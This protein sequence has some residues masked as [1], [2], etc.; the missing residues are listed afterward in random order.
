MNRGDLSLQ[1]NGVT[2]CDQEN[3]SR[4]LISRFANSTSSVTAIAGTRGAGKSSL[5]LRVMRSSNNDH[6][7]T[8]I[9]HCPIGYNPREFLVSIFQSVTD[10]VISLIDHRILGIDRSSQEGKGLLG[11]RAKTERRYLRG[12]R[13]ALLT[14]AGILLLGGLH[15]AIN[16]QIDLWTQQIQQ[17]VGLESGIATAHNKLQPPA[18][19]GDND[20]FSVAGSVQ[21]SVMRLDQ[22]SY[23][24]LRS[25]F[26]DREDPLAGLIFNDTRMKR[27]DASVGGSSSLFNLLTAIGERTEAIRLVLEARKGWAIR[28]LDWAHRSL[29]FVVVGIVITGA[30]VWFDGRITRRL[31]HAVKYPN[32]TGLRRVA[33]QWSEQLKYATTRSMA[34]GLGTDAASIGARKSL[35]TRSPSLASVA[36]G[37]REFLSHVTS[38]YGYA[39]I[40]L[41]E[42]DKIEDTDALEGLMRAIK[43]VLGQPRTH[44]LL[45]VSEDALSKFT[46][47]RQMDRGILESAFEHIEHLGTARLHVAAHALELMY[48]RRD[49]VQEGRGIHASTVLLWLFGA[50]VPREIKRN[51]LELIDLGLRPKNTM[52]WRLWRI[53]IFARLRSL[54]G[55]V[56]GVGGDDRETRDIL[57]CLDRTTQDVHK[58]L[59]EIGPNLQL[60]QR[61]VELWRTLL[62]R[63][64]SEDGQTSRLENESRDRS[65][66]RNSREGL[67]SLYGRASIEMILGASSLPY[68][69]KELVSGFQPSGI[70]RLARIFS[71]GHCNLEYAWRLVEEH[72]DYTGNIPR[73]KRR[74]ATESV[75]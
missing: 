64:I 57:A 58:T 12:F 35:V 52:L 8:Q 7:F 74:E 30:L 60:C 47:Q 70:E 50:A 65:W 45:T 62:L 2:Y 16:R 68:V 28:A 32:E 1:A 18:E 53:L 19:D 43:A 39:V 49:R 26:Q 73:R 67:P 59:G 48:P 33:L 4:R 13:I 14:G 54:T 15:Y 55:W 36:T 63:M 20:L 42:L 23:R 10:E 31:R 44:F 69:I 56:A 9:I 21:E 40:C 37:F 38:V 5:A 41:D 25:E 6:A 29:P 3:E 34:V 11:M 22:P 24:R 72:L 71:L 17:Y 75:E 51:A 66:E 61:L 27:L 46:A